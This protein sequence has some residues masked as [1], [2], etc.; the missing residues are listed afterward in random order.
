MSAKR[1]RIIHLIFAYILFW[2]F[3]NSDHMLSNSQVIESDLDNLIQSVF[4]ADRKTNKI[5][6]EELNKNN[7]THV[8]DDHNLQ[9]E[10]DP[11]FIA[12]FENYYHNYF[13]QLEKEESNR[14]SQDH[15]DFNFS[16]RQKL[17]EEKNNFAKTLYSLYGNRTIFKIDLTDLEKLVSLNILSENNAILF[18]EYLLQ[19]KTD[20]LRSFF[21]KIQHEESTEVYLFNF[22]PMKEIGFSFGSVVILYFFFLRPQVSPHSTLRQSFIYNLFGTLVAFCVIDTLYAWKY[23]VASSILFIQL[24]YFI[25][26]FIDSIM[27]NFGFIREDFEI[28]SSTVGVKSGMQF[29]LKLMVLIILTIQV[30]IL[31]IKRFNCILNY[32]VFY[33]CVF[34]IILLV[35]NSLHADVPVLFKP[36]KH[37]MFLMI[38]LGNFL[39]TKFH[40]RITRFSSLS[41]STLLKDRATNTQVDFIYLISE[42][43]SYF[44][45]SYVQEYITYQIY[46]IDKVK[47][48][49]QPGT[50]INK[51]FT[52]DDSLWLI[53]FIFGFVLVYVAYNRNEYCLF[54]FTVYYFKMILEIFGKIFNYK[55][56]RVFFSVVL[57]TLI[58][59]NQIISNRS[60]HYI[61]EL[62]NLHPGTSTYVIYFIKF[63]VKAFGLC[64]ILYTIFLN[65]DF[66][67]TIHSEKNSE[68]EEMAEEAAEEI[69]RKVE[70]ASKFD[71]KRNRKVT[72]FQIQVVRPERVF[73][74]WNV[75]YIHLDFYTNFVSVCLIFY[76]MKEIERNYFIIMFYT[77]LIFILLARVNKKFKLLGLLHY[78]R[79]QK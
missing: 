10:L 19:Q 18:W 51:S 77:L 73:N 55:L 50:R 30:G 15:D 11:E 49:L 8:D 74:F 65:F 5:S 14:K 22:I 53:P 2:F 64:L 41:F 20:R 43:F 56:F 12:D 62:F 48:K 3:S 34:F 72:T 27:L 24:I 21:G 76:F 57:F 67:Y 38:G 79:I 61:F 60:D 1:E 47:N 4:Y 26:C 58:L 28:F 33:F 46:T 17:I 44:C 40:R 31:S 66:I 71:K 54:L 78:Q 68:I 69:L 25:K 32:L 35:C 75:I 29:N 9:I 36:L 42:V 7:F 70:I 63:M 37:T 16:A 45:L 6:Y 23:Y 13:S 52:F 59:L 39:V